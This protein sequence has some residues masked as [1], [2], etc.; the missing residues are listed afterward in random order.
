MA[1]E[2]GIRRGLPN[3]GDKDF[4][5]RPAVLLARLAPKRGWL[6]PYTPPVQQAPA[7][8]DIHVLTLNP[9]KRSPD[10]SLAP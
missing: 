1:D 6:A 10:E 3:Y 8:R 5:Q 2:T 4:A 9:S 7:C